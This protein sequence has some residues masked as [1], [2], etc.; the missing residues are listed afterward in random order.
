M[1]TLD[2][3]TNNARGFVGRQRRRGAGWCRNLGLPVAADTQ[4]DG[5]G[6]QDITSAKAIAG[7]AENPAA[8][9]TPQPRGRGLGGGR[10]AGACRSNGGAAGQGPG[11]GAGRG[12]GGGQGRRGRI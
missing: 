11:R 7:P 2:L 5:T 9:V 4:P 12:A 8:P 1:E 3:T 10:G 6:T